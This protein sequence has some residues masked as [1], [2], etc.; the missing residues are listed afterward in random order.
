MHFLF[1]VLIKNYT[2]DYIYR[3]KERVIITANIYS[4]LIR[5]LINYL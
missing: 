3:K 4:H 5:F 1:N 2:S